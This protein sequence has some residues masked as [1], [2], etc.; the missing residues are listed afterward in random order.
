IIEAYRGKHLAIR[1]GPKSLGHYTLAP[2]SQEYRFGPFSKTEVEKDANGDAVSDGNGKPKMKYYDGNDVS[3]RR[4][5]DSRAKRGTENGNWLLQNYSMAGRLGHL[6]YARERHI[7]ERQLLY[8]FANRFICSLG[9]S[10]PVHS[11]SV[12]LLYRNSLPQL[13]SHR[14]SLWLASG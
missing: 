14:A 8:M 12:R 10:A 13:L 5:H 2:S 3:K 11:P 7:H 9:Q 4:L 1:Y 6:L